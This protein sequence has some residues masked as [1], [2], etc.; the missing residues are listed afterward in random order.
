M[1]RACPYRHTVSS[2]GVSSSI[3][4]RETS[5]ARIEQRETLVSHCSPRSPRPPF[6]S[7]TNTEEGRK[8][9]V[10]RPSLSSEAWPAPLELLLPKRRALG[11]G[12]GM[13]MMMTVRKATLRHMHDSSLVFPELGGPSHSINKYVLPPLEQ[14]SSFFCIPKSFSRKTVK[15]RSPQ[16]LAHS[17]FSD[18]ENSKCSVR[19]TRARLVQKTLAWV[20]LC[21]S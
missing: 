14:H 6:H 3:K 9:S 7:S 2:A 17:S 15:E 21:S 8:Y 11:V 16:K 20:H 19:I 5:A 12:P 10:P 13:A 18:E 4:D 1:K